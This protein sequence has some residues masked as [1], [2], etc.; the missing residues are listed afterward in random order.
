[1]DMIRHAMVSPRFGNGRHV[2]Q[3]LGNAQFILPETLFV[4]L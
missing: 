3:L 1:M 4:R 2:E